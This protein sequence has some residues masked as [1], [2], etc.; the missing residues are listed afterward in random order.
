MSK[1]RFFLGY[2]VDFQGICWVYPPKV[3]E[4]VGNTEYGIYVKIL[5]MSQEEIED[6]YNEQG[7]DM[8]KLLNP[9]EY[10]LN[11][12]YHNEQLRQLT[13]NAFQ[14]FIHE[15]VLVL[16]E[17]KMV[18]VGEL[19]EGMKVEDLRLL[20][21]DKFFEFQNLIRQSVGDKAIEPPKEDEDPRVKRIKAKAR[22]R[23]RVKAKKGLGLNLSTLLASICCMGYSINPLNIG[24]LS[25]AAIPILM[26][27]YQ[28]K[29]AYET[30]IRALMAGADSKKVK[31]EYWIRNLD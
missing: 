14:F 2:P 20:K 27:T 15:K 18:V 12:Y 5:T 28:A 17:M 22:Y 24:E 1:E 30:D 7:L 4:V 19:K 13:I 25:Y 16:P 9:F 11:N 31:P 26:E 3:S 21:E 29:E 6:Q 23:D 8:S 10:M